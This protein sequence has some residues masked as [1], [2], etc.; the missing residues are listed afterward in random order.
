L[1]KK[2]NRE[3]DG[4][5]MKNLVEELKGWVARSLKKIVLESAE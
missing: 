1:Y 2:G 3:R 4:K 5:C